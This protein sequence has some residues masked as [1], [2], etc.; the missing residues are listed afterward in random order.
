[1]LF[2]RLATLILIF[3]SSFSCSC[4]FLKPLPSVFL[5]LPLFSDVVIIAS[6]EYKRVSLVA[7]WKRTCL[8]IQEMQISI[9]GLG[10]RH[11]VRNE[12]ATHSSVLAWEI[13]GQRS[14]MG[15]SPWDCKRDEHDLVTKQQ[16]TMNTKIKPYSTY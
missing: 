14:L 7:Q 6:H 13:H 15:Y 8:S 16:T 1:M 10:I 9:P 2:L 3:P 5:P 4:S 12:R 11:A